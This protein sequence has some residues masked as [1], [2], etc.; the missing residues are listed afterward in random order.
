MYTPSPKLQDPL[1]T[2]KKLDFAI[3]NDVSDVVLVSL[4]LTLNIFH[5]IIDLEH[6]NVCW[7]DVGRELTFDDVGRNG[8]VTSSLNCLLLWEFIGDIYSLWYEGLIYYKD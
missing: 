5:T 8:G 1:D 4:I 6:I 3:R 7:D 2:I